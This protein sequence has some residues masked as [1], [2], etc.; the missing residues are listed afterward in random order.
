MAVYLRVQRS[1]SDEDRLLTAFEMSEFAREL[2]R[3]GIRNQHPE[4]TEREVTRELI[5]RA[6]FPKPLPAALR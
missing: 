2:S 1:R 6:F 3:V 4:W 5:R